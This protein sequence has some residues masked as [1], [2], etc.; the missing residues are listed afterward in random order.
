MDVKKN[1]DFW[2]GRE[3]EGRLKGIKT[4]FIV[5]DKSITEICN[6]LK[7]CGS[8]SHLYF[9]AGNQSRVRDFNILEYFSKKYYIT[10][11]IILEDILCVPVSIYKNK[12]I[13]IILTIPQFDFIHLLKDT[14]TIKIQNSD[15]VYCIS[16]ENMFKTNRKEDYKGDEKI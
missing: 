11:E 13:H 1:T 5:G 10:L 2:V 12:N 6:K 15:Y 3:V 8:V 4:L 16:K 14:D 9:G 7:Q